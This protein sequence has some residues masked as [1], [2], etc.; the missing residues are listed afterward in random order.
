M[1][2]KKECWSKEE[3]KIY[4]L[5]LCAKTDL[6]ESDEELDLIKSKTSLDVFEK[7]YME[8]GEDTEEESLKKIQYNIQRHCYSFREIR[9]LN[10]EV[11][12]VFFAD[13]KLLKKEQDLG[14]LLENIL[15]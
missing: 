3:L 8:F 12:Q 6:V 1:K 2:T 10:K 7:M 4:I 9:E 11:R 14:L 5:L 13:R 15:Y